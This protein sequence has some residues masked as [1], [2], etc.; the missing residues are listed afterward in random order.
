[1]IFNKDRYKNIWTA[2]ADEFGK[3]FFAGLLSLPANMQRLM[4]NTFDTGTGN[5]KITFFVQKRITFI[6]IYG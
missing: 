3:L 6:V 4:D 2:E 1:M 5:K